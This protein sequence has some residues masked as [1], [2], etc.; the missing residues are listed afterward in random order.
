[1]AVRRL[2]EEVFIVTET[3]VA[4]E[5][6]LLLLRLHIGFWLLPDEQSW[7]VYGA[8]LQCDFSQVWTNLLQAGGRDVEL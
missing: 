1:M 7:V 5:R 2:L 3:F 4:P 8:V 6:L